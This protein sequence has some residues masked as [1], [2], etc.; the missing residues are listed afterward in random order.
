MYF[1]FKELISKSKNIE[2]TERNMRDRKSK[3]I[4]VIFTMSIGNE[5]T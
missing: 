5:L 1:K 2:R 3:E 4:N